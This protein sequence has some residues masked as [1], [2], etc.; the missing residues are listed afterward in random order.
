MNR[1]K[2]LQAERMKRRQQKVKVRRVVAIAVLS[3][4]AVNL[5]LLGVNVYAR[6]SGK[7]SERTLAAQ[8]EST[9]APVQTEMTAPPETE[10]TPPETS[11]EPE[12]TL[13]SY[14]QDP[15]YGAIRP[16]ENFGLVYVAAPFADIYD[17]AD[18][19]G[20]IIGKSRCYSGVNVLNEVGDFYEIEY[21]GFT[22]F[23]EKKLILRG[24]EAEAR[25]LEVAHSL[26]EVLEDDQPVLSAPR[27]DAEPLF[28][29]KKDWKLTILDRIGDWYK[30][31]NKDRTGYVRY[32]ED[33]IIYALDESFFFEDPGTTVSDLRLDILGEAFHWFGTPYVWG[34]ETLGE[35]VDC[36]AY[37]WLVY[38]KFGISMPRLS[39]EQSEWGEEVASMDDILPGD[40]L[41]FRGYHDENESWTEGV[42]HV[43][44][45]CGNGKMIHAASVERG[46]VV[47]DYDYVEAPLGIRRVIFD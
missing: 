5:I 29:A 17:T 9:T 13:S 30:V 35:G 34:G 15:R 36:S 14:E 18:L 39:V 37:V 38:A 33:N 28:L 32:R 10:T 3:L 31:N 46:I 43:G 25:A 42:G 2:E 41:F 4:A 8:E 1:L 12:T 21:Q 16:F 11:T 7:G 22:G 19:N 26:Y 44:I 20:R 6:I 45:Y 23:I 40:L 27:D 24:E 47:D